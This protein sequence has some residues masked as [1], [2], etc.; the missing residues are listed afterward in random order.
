MIGWLA[1]NVP[2]EIAAIQ[3]RGGLNDVDLAWMTQE[4]NDDL[5][6]FRPI[7]IIA[8]ADEFLLYPRSQERAEQAFLV[9][10]KLLALMAFLPLGVRFAGLRFSTD[11]NGFVEDDEW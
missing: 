6:D 1:V 4:I 9:L 2:L 8:R 11:I 7:N 3:T 5:N 10:R